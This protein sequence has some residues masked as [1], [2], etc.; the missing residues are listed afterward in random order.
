MIYG[1]NNLFFYFCLHRLQ[2]LN[3][4]NHGFFNYLQVFELDLKFVVVWKIKFKYLKV[5][6]MFLQ[7][8]GFLQ[9]LQYWCGEHSNVYFLVNQVCFHN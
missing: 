7:V 8:F 3:W 2:K 1:D 9:A 5:N 4:C 6:E